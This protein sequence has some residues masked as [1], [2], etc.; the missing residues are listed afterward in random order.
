MNFDIIGLDETWLKNK[1]ID[2]FMLNGYNL[3]FKN[4][5]KK[6]GGGVCLFIRDNIKYHVRDDLSQLKNPDFVE[7]L[8]IEIEKPHSKN[9]VVGVMYRPPGQDLT[10]FNEYFDSVLKCVTRNQKIVYLMGDFNVNLLNE[11][12]HSH[13]NDFINILTSHSFYP[14]ITKP[15]RITSRSATLI[16]NIF[17]NS[18]A[19]QTSGIVISDISDHLPIFVKTNL[20]VFRTRNEKSEI[21]VREFS[22]ANIENLK[23]NLITPIGLLLCNSDDVNVSYSNF[24]N[25]FNELYDKCIPMKK[26]RIHPKK[27][28]PKL[29]WITPALLKSIKRKNK[30]YR[31]SIKKPTDKNIEKYKKYRNKLNSLLRLGKA[32]SLIATYFI[33]KKIICE[34]PG[35]Y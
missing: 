18:K 7:S 19:L 21:E 12:T 32:Q 6:R 29:P 30:L 34:I 8:F 27:N 35:K 22:S 10:A 33:K 4:R 15:T 14:S 31:M 3:E 28:K 2:Y 25:K 11:D 17:T 23:R 20:N 13:T 1:P 16:D 26:K 24:I 9:I 5:D